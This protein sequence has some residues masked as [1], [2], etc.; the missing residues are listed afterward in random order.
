MRI[1]RII[2][3]TQR[4]LLYV[5]IHYKPSH[6]TIITH[7]ILDDFRIFTLVGHDMFQCRMEV[8]LQPSHAITTATILLLDQQPPK[9][10]FTLETVKIAIYILPLRI[11]PSLV[12]EVFHN[13]PSTLSVPPCRFI[14][15]PHRS[16][17]TRMAP[18]LHFG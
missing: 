11:I 18:P 4:L 1:R 10:P 3:F 17:R 2:Y 12:Q 15:P 9:F 7:I 6:I 5:T 8:I 14:N 13:T 16:I